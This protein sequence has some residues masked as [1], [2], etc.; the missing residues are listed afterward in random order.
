LYSLPNTLLNKLQRVQ[1]TSARIVTK[2]SKHQSITSILKKLH[3][4]PVK[5]RIQFKINILTWKSLHGQA[6]GYI[7]ELLIPYVPTRDLRSSSQNILV[8]PK[9]N[10][11]YGKRAFASAAP[12]L[13][14]SLPTTLRET[15]SY[16]T[17]KNKLKT[18]LFQL[19]YN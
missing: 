9:C 6:P 16:E 1:N 18:H 7:E 3:W 12:A 15:D 17:F 14:N 13:W 5:Q 4:L 11:Q 10:N 2:S 19:A 8:I